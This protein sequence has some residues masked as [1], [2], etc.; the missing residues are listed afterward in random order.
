[1]DAGSIIHLGGGRDLYGGS[2]K[3]A[4]FKCYV[5]QWGGGVYELGQIMVY[6]IMLLVLLRGRGC[7]IS[8]K[9]H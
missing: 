7:P 3:G 2:T 6:G 4:I 9:K 5:M 1:M 8:R